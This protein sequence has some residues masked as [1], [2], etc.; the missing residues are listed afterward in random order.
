MCWCSYRRTTCLLQARVHRCYRYA[1]NI[2]DTAR[3]RTIPRDDVRSAFSQ[4]PHTSPGPIAFPGSLTASV[5]SHFPTLRSDRICLHHFVS[6]VWI[7]QN[8]SVFHR[9]SFIA[10][11]P[12]KRLQGCPVH[13]NHLDTG[14]M[15]DHLPTA[16]CAIEWR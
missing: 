16:H 15:Q 12:Q 6:V 8:I 14:L 4:A 10:I 13:H 3:Y 1:H 2:C 5:V 9:I 11:R 7:Y